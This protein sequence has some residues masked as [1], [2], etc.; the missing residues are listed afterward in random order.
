M[1]KERSMALTLA[2]IQ[3][4]EAHA[5]Q[6]TLAQGANAVPPFDARAELLAVADA[7]V[8]LFHMIGDRAVD[9]VLGVVPGT[10]IGV[11]HSGET[12]VRGVVAVIPGVKAFS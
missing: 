7:A 1:V 3:E 4:F 11:Y 10:L 2:E 8:D 12:A 6:A 9:K 5:L